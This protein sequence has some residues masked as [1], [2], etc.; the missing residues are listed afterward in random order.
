MPQLKRPLTFS[1]WVTAQ[2]TPKSRSADE[3]AARER[4]RERA[5]PFCLAN[6]SF[7]EFAGAKIQNYTCPVCCF[8]C[9]KI[10]FFFCSFVFLRE[11][12]FSPAHYDIGDVSWED[13]KKTV[14]VC[15]CVLPLFFW[16]S[17]FVFFLVFSFLVE[18]II[19]IHC[20]RWWWG[21]T[22]RVL[23]LFYLYTNIH[24]FFYRQFG[25]WNSEAVAVFLLCGFH[26]KWWIF[27]V[28]ATR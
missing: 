26:C 9:L 4:E 6:P 15:V 20:L 5:R 13:V 17:V 22:P 28:S 3:D 19:C 8:F 7:L 14:C 24:W 25:V 16:L 11:D 1:T 18:E 21:N 23:R 27:S 12:F 2:K 10:F